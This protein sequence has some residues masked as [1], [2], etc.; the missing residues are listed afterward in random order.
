MLVFFLFGSDMAWLLRE[1]NDFIRPGG[2][3]RGWGITGQRLPAESALS[4]PT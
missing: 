1:D 2:W 4:K 3:G